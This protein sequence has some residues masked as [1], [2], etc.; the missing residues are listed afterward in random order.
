MEPNTKEIEVA[1]L[2]ASSKVAEDDENDLSFLNEEP[3]PEP[4]PAKQE[5]TSKTAEPPPVAPV[6]PTKHEHPRYLAEMARRLG[7]TEELLAS[8]PTDQLGA[9]VE[10]AMSQITQQTRQQPAPVKETPKVEVDPD[11]AEIKYLEEEVGVDPKVAAF[12]RKQNA[13]LKTLETQKLAEVEK[14]VKETQER[15]QRREKQAREQFFDATRDSMPEE[16]RP[17]FGKSGEATQ[18]QHTRYVNALIAANLD[19]NNDTPAV[20]RR[21][22]NEAAKML[23]GDFIKPIEKAVVPEPPPA[24]KPKPKPPGKHMTTQEWDNAV[25]GKPLAQKRPP[26]RGEKAQREAVANFFREHNLPV[27]G[28]AE[29]E[30]FD[31]IPE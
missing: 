30:M 11:E 25:V 10:G 2:A 22:I 16:F 5:A 15:E 14:L 6:Q 3:E 9:M 4:E 31:G 1:N 19:V 21:K 27:N 20:M 12:L 23:Y 26:T 13:K 24:E 17:I 7:A 8:T 29:D 18:T 28:V